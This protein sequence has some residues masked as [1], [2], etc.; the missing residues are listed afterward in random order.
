MKIIRQSG[1]QRTKMSQ[2]Q[3]RKFDLNIEKILEGWELRHAIREVLANALD[4]QALTSSAEIRINKDS[5][6]VWHV[7]DYGRGLRYEHLTQNENKE[8]LR[9]ESKVVGKFGVGLKDALATLHRRGTSVVIRSKHGD[10]ELEMTSKHGFSDV[11]TLHAVIS[12]PG[13]PKQIGT[14]VAF[15][16]ISDGDMAAAKKFFLKFSGDKILDSTQY[17]QILRRTQGGKARVYVKGLLVAE[18]EDFAFSYNITSL[19]AAMNKALNRERTNVG[20]TAYADRVKAMLLASD[21]DEVAET[22]TNDLTRMEQG[23]NR[24]EVKWVDVAV[25]ACQ[26]LNAKRKVVFVTA[27]QR[28]Q[29]SDAI[30]HAISDGYKVVTVPENIQERLHGARDILGNPVRDLEVFQTEFAASFEFAFVDRQRLSPAERRIF[31]SQAELAKLVGGLPREVK[32][33]RISE[34]MRP[35]F[36][37]N[38]DAAGLWE[39]QKRRIIIKRSQLRS[40]EGFAGTLLHEITHARSGCEDVTREFE[41]ELTV[42][43]GRASAK[44]IS[45]LK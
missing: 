28:T 29:A 17:G 44:A 40:L 10:I 37:S 2:S 13:D 1:S 31:D 20:R 12:P 24:D 18:E 7:R 9:Y 16:G 39:P 6:G 36:A 32:E 35:D 34:T 14:D 45:H 38:C 23:T 3:V 27:D 11:A 25:H 43:L 8:K 26:I 19:T 5:K 33:I 42:T 30:D 15:N 41:N 21:S 22:L 4:E